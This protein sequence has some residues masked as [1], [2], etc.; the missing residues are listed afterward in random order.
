MADNAQ[1]SKTSTT[2]ETTSNTPKPR[3]KLSHQ[4]KL[5]ATGIDLDAL[6]HPE[7]PYDFDHE[8]PIWNEI[9]PGLYQGGTYDTDTLGEVEAGRD[10]VITPDQFD[11]VVTLYQWANPVDWFVRELRYAFY[12]HDIEHFPLEQLFDLVKIAHADWKRGKRVLVRCQAGINRSG[13]VTALILIR[14]G[15]SAAEAITMQRAARSNWVL[16][17]RRFVDFLMGLDPEIWRGDIFN[18]EKSGE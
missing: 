15:Y 3:K 11:T 9:L 16:A 6:Y 4:E 17:N 13:L 12:D 1:P 7:L 18:T 2:S 8:R 5:A 10:M 14:E